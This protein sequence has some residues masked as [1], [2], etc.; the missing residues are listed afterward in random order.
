MSAAVMKVADENLSLMEM[1]GNA[2]EQI[3][4]YGMLR[5][6]A[7]RSSHEATLAIFRAGRWLS[8][9]RPKFRA[10]GRGK[11]TAFLKEYDI[12]RTTGWEAETLFKRAKT[13]AAVSGI[14][15]T[16]AKEK[17]KVVK[18]KKAKT[19]PVNSVKADQTTADLSSDGGVS[20][21]V[22][23]RRPGDPPSDVS[24][25]SDRAIVSTPR[26]KPAER[27]PTPAQ[28]G[29]DVLEADAAVPSVAAERDV[30]PAASTADEPPTP[31]EQHPAL[32][33]LV[34]IVNRLDLFATDELSSAELTAEQREAIGREVTRA[35]D[36]LRT[37]EGGIAR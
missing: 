10:E 35:I 24:S 30:E 3:D 16:A 7:R 31:G 18:A 37:I 22:P 29:G 19:Q 12:P 6:Q 26:P 13:E 11:W 5:V 9:A 8:L 28:P 17:F 21:V 23:F 14:T 20:G 2:Y 27:G 36:L 1:M 25:N 33:T 34:Q 4:L 32:T 15:P